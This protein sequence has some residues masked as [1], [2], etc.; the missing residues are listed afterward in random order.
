M[1]GFTG[2]VHECVVM[3]ESP[4]GEASGGKMRW[5]EDIS[6]RLEDDARGCV[7][8]S[9]ECVEEASID[10]L[11]A[12]DVELG[13]AGIDARDGSSVLKGARVGAGVARIGTGVE[14]VV[15]EVERANGRF[16]F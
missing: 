5:L 12:S 16:L 9:K 7:G 1:L 14:T 10:W 2:V 6:V 4:G 15:A 11:D 8:G 3:M 13:G